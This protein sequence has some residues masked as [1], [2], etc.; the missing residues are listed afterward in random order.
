M[1][2]NRTRK[3][4]TD[5]DLTVLGTTVGSDARYVGT[6]ADVGV[7]ASRRVLERARVQWTDRNGGGRW[8]R[9]DHTVFEAG[10]L[11]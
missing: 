7:M 4:A 11:L 6:G 9:R 5:V 3:V 8:I 2:A 10:E 1:G